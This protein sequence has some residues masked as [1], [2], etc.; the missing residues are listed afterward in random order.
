M[1]RLKCD[2][3][4]TQCQ[5]LV[6]GKEERLP[7][8]VREGFFDFGDM[9]SAADMIQS[10][11]E[12]SSEETCSLK[13]LKETHTREML[14]MED[15]MLRAAQR[16]KGMSEDGEEDPSLQ[17][18]E[19]A[20]SFE[21]EGN[22]EDAIAKSQGFQESLACKLQKSNYFGEK[23]KGYLGWSE[24]SEEIYKAFDVSRNTM[25]PGEAEKR[26]SEKEAIEDMFDEPWNK[27]LRNAFLQ[28]M[29]L[30]NEDK[31]QKNAAPAQ[32]VQPNAQ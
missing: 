1:Y 8:Y 30:L 4:G 3:S 13:G 6:G 22:D 10:A 9:P 5:T 11:M 18:G 29:V 24:F 27:K 19:P 32:T 20:W 26:E 25:S 31:V 14:N 17:G 16:G 7:Q 2:A 21:V 15:D 28:N 23:G 12:T